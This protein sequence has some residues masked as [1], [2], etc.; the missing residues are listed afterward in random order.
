[1]FPIS[2]SYLMETNRTPESPQSSPML[3]MQGNAPSRTSISFI[4][5]LDQLSEAL[6]TRHYSRRTEDVY[7]MW[8]KRNCRFHRMRHPREMTEEHVNAYLSHLAVSEH[9]SASTQNQALSALL[10]L[11]RY[12]LDQPLGE[13]HSVLYRLHNTARRFSENGETYSQKWF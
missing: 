3:P 10:F 7:A 2:G 4:R 6:R 1:M 5:S 11:Y 9:V 8:V 13:L 12:V